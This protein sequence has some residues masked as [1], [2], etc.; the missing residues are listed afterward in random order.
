MSA[1]ADRRVIWDPRRQ[2]RFIVGGGSQISLYGWN[3]SSSGFSL[4][5]AR[6]EFQ[7]MK[8]RNL[9]HFLFSV[10]HSTL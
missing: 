7:L 6:S 9:A 4:I 8:V 10:A 5:T 2:N 3:P 1:K